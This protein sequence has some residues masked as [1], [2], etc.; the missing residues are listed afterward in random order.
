MDHFGE[1]W[2]GSGWSNNEVLKELNSISE[3]KPP[4]RYG[5]TRAQPPTGSDVN[6]IGDFYYHNNVENIG[7]SPESIVQ[8][9]D[10]YYDY[11]FI[12]FHEDLEE[13]AENDAEGSRV[14]GVPQ[15]AGPTQMAPTVASDIT[16]IPKV[17]KESLSFPLEREET[18]DKILDPPGDNGTAEAENSKDWDDF[19]SEDYLLPV[20][21]T[22]VVQHSQTQE[23]RNNHLSLPTKDVNLPEVENGLN[24]TED[25]LTV[26]FDASQTTVS[27]IPNTA[28]NTPVGNDSLYVYSYY[29]ESNV[30]PEDQETFQTI[31]LNES[32]SEIPQTTSQSFVST[33]GFILEDLDSDHSDFGT[34]YATGRYSWATDFNPTTASLSEEYTLTPLPYLQTSGTQQAFDISTSSGTASEPPTSL[35]GATQVSPADLLPAARKYDPT[36][37]PS[38]ERGGAEFSPQAPWLD[39]ESLDETLTPVS[40]TERGN[41][42]PSAHPDPPASSH[43]TVFWPFQLP[44][45]IQTTAFPQVTFSGYWITGNWSAVSPSIA[46]YHTFSENFVFFD[47]ILYM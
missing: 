32:A 8:V 18:V 21:P 27:G 36:G 40:M 38:A 39:L 28:T 20:S 10:F 9:D 19:L 24:F 44:T 26:N 16:A 12:N 47:K 29:E 15:D 7:H 11:N 2:S 17:T 23:E 31:Q 33:S 45:S 5:T 43:P 14:F 6:A 35:E 1:D 3:L 41:R 46:L 25:T 34:T 42:L 22:P 30:I 4:P 13:T 37:L